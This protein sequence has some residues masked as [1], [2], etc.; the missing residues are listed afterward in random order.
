MGRFAMPVSCDTCAR[1]LTPAEALAC[2]ASG[3]L[4]LF[5]TETFY[6]LG[7]LIQFPKA[8]AAIRTLKGR[9]QGKPLPLAAASVTQIAR[10]CDL[11]VLPRQLTAFWP[12][13][14]TLVLPLKPKV[15]LDPCLV[16]EQGQVAVRISAH[17][18][19]TWLADCCDELLTVSSANVQ[20]RAPAVSPATL[21]PE[22]LSRLEG[23]RLAWGILPHE[24][25]QSPRG[26]LPSTIVRPDGE[27]LVIL[28][29]G[30][31]AA[32]VLAEHGFALS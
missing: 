20:G 24:P 21:D 32:Q 8:L 29:Q 14:L 11:S 1:I 10:F 17:P 19:P 13:P 9:N 30:A 15:R 2:L 16:N 6:A 25:E 12:G 7:C 28:R 26:G 18:T 31:L 4:L 5:P 3:G 27:R 23:L 22:L